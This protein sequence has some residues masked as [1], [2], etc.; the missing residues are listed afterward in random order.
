MKGKVTVN[1]ALT[2]EQTSKIDALIQKYEEN[3]S[4]DNNDLGYYN[5]TEFNI[6]TKNEKPIKT[7][8]YR[9]AYAQQPEVDGMIDEMLVNNIIKKSNSPWAS[10]LVIVKKKDGTNRFCVDYR[11]INEITVKD[12]FPVPL[13]EETLDSLQGSQY[14]TTIDLA[15]GYWQMALNN[16]AKLKTAFISSKG[17]FQFERLPFGLSNAVSFFQR[18]METIFEGVP[19]IKI[20]IDDIMVHSKTFEEHLLHLEEVFIILKESN[21][22]IKASKCLFGATETKFLGYDIN[23]EGIRPNNDKIKAMLKYPVPKTQKQV[24]RFLGMASYYRKFIPNYS[25]ITEAINRLLKKNSK[26]VWNEKCQNSFTLIIYYLTHPPLLSFPNFKKDFFLCLIIHIVMT[27][28]KP[29]T[30]VCLTVRT[31]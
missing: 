20:Y 16:D 12:N 17:L 31:I 2:T 3:F 6:D 26:F 19:N 28:Q 21:L 24:K 5:K 30:Q 27:G 13:I 25:S 29:T 22:K 9:V 23:K 8:P 4:K 14:F 15:S 18:T 1:C 10:P 11:K 7:K